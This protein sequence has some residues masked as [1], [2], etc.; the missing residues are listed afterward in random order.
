MSPV[1]ERHQDISGF[2]ESVLRIFVEAKRLGIIRSAPFTMRLDEQTAREPDLMFLASEHQDRLLSTYL[3]GPADLAVEIVS[4]DS[5]GRDRGD[6]FAEY[7]RAGVEE[8]WLI[9]PIRQQAEFYVLTEGRYYLQALDN[10]IYH[11]TVLPGL[12]LREEWFWQEPIP[13]VLD[14][15]RFLQVIE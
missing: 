8:Y 12:T 4:P 1:S 9:D 3:D 14:V 10:G 5:I 11:S 13:N 6:K 15:L 7:E 2:L